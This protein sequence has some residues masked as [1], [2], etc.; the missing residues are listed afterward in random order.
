MKNQMNYQ[1]IKAKIKDADEILE[2]Q[3]LA[4]Q[5]EAKLYNNYN[6]TPLKQTIEELI[7]QFKDHVILKAVSENK[8]IGTV[9]AYEKD[10]TCYVGRLAVHP[11]MQDQGIGTALMNEIEKHYKPKSF[12][13]F[14]GSK[15]NNNIRLYQKLGYNVYQKDQ[16]ECGNIEVLYMEKII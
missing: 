8:I 9:R 10:G 6:I 2:I 1:I 12:E 4:F 13:L 15:S 11:D 5:I 3:K 16:Y 14:V 7:T